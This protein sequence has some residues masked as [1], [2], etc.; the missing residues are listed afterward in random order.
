MSSASITAFEVS[1]QEY[2]DSCYRTTADEFE[3]T[4]QDAIE[5]PAVG[6][7]MPFDDVS[8][9]GTTVETDPSAEAIRTAKTGVVPAGL[10][11]A[12]YGTLTIES[13]PTGDELISLYPNRCVIVVGA[14]DIVPDLSVAFE[15]LGDDLASGNTAHILAS[16]PSKTG[17]LGGLI[18]GVH[19]P[20][21]ISVV[22]LEDR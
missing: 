9:E 7:P 8:L 10:G 15:R 20:A 18:E 6:A 14:S 1:L 4:I 12:S 5:A 16:G 19:G 21:H 11:V 2:V 13:R 3:R 17:D 22:V